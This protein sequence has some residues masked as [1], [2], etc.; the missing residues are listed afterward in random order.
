MKLKIAA[1]I[2]L[3]AV[4]ILSLVGV[5]ALQIKTMI[6]AGASMG[7]MATSVEVRS[8]TKDSWEQGISS[9]GGRRFVLKRMVLYA[10]SSLSREQK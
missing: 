1:A 9:V 6:E 4:I 2:V 7:P 3:V 5:K 10:R 8:A